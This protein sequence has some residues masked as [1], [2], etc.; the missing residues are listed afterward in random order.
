MDNS[1]LNLIKRHIQTLRSQLI[2]RPND[3]K[4]LNELGIAYLQK[5][6][7]SQ[8]T[9][10]L[11]QA[12]VAADGKKADFYVSLGQVLLRSERNLEAICAFRQALS[13]EKN[14]AMAYCGLGLAL[15]ANGEFELSI[16]S[17]RAATSAS[18]N[19]AEFWASLAHVLIK[20]HEYQEAYASAKRALQ[21]SNC[22]NSECLCL[23]QALF[24]LRKF[25]PALRWLRKGIRINPKWADGY[26]NIGR[27]LCAQEKFRAAK[28]YYK[29]A[30]SLSPNH[31]EAHFGLAVSLLTDGNFAEG[32]KEY[33]W[34]FKLNK[35]SNSSPCKLFMQGLMEPM[36]NGEE[37]NGK[38]LLVCAEQGFGDIFQ[39]VRYV[40]E[41]MRIGARILLLVYPELIEL[42]RPLVPPGAIFAYNQ[43]LPRYDY[44]IP[45]F[46]LPRMLKTTLDSIPSSV[47][48][49]PAPAI[50]KIPIQ[51]RKRSNLRIGLVWSSRRTGSLDFRSIPIENIEPLYQ[52]KPATFFSFQVDDK[53]DE[54]NRYMHKYSNIHSLKPYIK[55]WRDTASLIAKMDLILSIDTGLAHLAGG[56]GKPIWLMLS[57][58]ADW[59]YLSRNE[60]DT[61]SPWYPTMRLYRASSLSSWKDVI[62]RI[63][64]DLIKVIASQKFFSR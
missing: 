41:L 53:A 6:D 29:R 59:R 42:L 26:Y 45:L 27:A 3:G 36:W 34:R 52:I 57:Y 16:S 17:L 31:A 39:A 11:C 30:I 43:L 8:A 49:I 64:A 56:L 13:L 15:S 46:S 32:W 10:C 47:P 62:N 22:Y 19:N 61:K 1:E 54:L 55:N 33:E 58:G 28:R 35:S 63:K 51:L 23:V 4:I 50:S 7:I 14:L 25:E 5:N 9:S 37:I 18:S 38:T 44:Y 12:V 21:I 60:W 20:T 24:G 2:Q 48:Y 40:Q